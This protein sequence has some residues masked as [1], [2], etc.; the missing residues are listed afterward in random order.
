MQIAEKVDL[1]LSQTASLG[2]PAILYLCSAALGKPPDLSVLHLCCAAFD[3]PL[4]HS[5][6]PIVQLE[7]DHE[8]LGVSQ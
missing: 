8:A 6:H 5:A 3:S 7:V 1:G 2:C 4:D